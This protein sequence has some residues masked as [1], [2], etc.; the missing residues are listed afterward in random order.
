MARVAL[1]REPGLRTSGGERPLRARMYYFALL[2]GE[3]LTYNYTPPFR[4]TER[5]D[6]NEAGRP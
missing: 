1:K 4:I 3:V 5:A 2:R 6:A